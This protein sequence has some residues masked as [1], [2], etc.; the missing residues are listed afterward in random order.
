MNENSHSELQQI[1]TTV[2]CIMFIYRDYAVHLDLVLF[3]TMVL[4]S[5][6]SAIIFHYLSYTLYRKTYISKLGCELPRTI[7]LFDSR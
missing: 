6:L 2:L 4:N 3:H 5:I 7:L 1:G